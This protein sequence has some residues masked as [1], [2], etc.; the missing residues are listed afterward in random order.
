M[1]SAKS[2]MFLPRDSPGAKPWLGTVRGNRS[3]RPTQ[4][5]DTET[6]ARAWIAATFQ[7]QECPEGGPSPK[8]TKG[9]LLTPTL[10]AR[11]S[12]ENHDRH[13]HMNKYFLQAMSLF[14]NDQIL[15]TVYQAMSSFQWKLQ[16]HRDFSSGPVVKTSSS[17]TRGYGFNPWS[18]SLG[19]TRLEAKKPKD[20]TEAIV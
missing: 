16:I 20:K 9:L 14:P 1:P 3:T 2:P 7:G 11:P 18:G 17:N 5:N 12:T 19:H 4:M 8:A 10:S 13:C 6:G 15:S